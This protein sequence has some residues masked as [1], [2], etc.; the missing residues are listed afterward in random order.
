MNKVFCTNC[1]KI[2]ESKSVHDFVQCD[3]ENGTF[4]DGGNDYCRRGGKDLS[5]VIVVTSKSM[6]KRLLSQFKKE[7]ET[8]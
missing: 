5:K 2:L 4:T 6:E 8:K 7:K 3:C 1:G